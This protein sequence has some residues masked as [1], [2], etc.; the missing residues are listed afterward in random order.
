MSNLRILGDS[1]ADNS[2][3]T[4]TATS[5]ALSIGNVL[6]TQPSQVWRSTTTAA[7]NIDITLSGEKTISGFCLYN[8]NLSDGATIQLI[9]SNSADFSSPVSDTT[10]NYLDPQYGFGEGEYGGETGFGGFSEDVWRY[11]FFVRWLTTTAYAT[12]W[13]ITITDATNSDGYIQFGR[14]KLGSYWTP[15]INMEFGYGVK[16]VDPSE[17]TRTR[18]GAL[19][20]EN[21][22]KYRKINVKFNYLDASEAVSL[23]DIMR[24]IGY[25]SDILFDA[26]P[27]EGSTE[28]AVS[29]VL[30]RLT[31]WSPITTGIYGRQISITIQE[32]I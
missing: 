14:L 28:S 5:E 3:A 17:Q 22:E 9:G 26:L 7:Q 11:R 1:V 20:S 24:T 30:G 23:H 10:W 12:Y 19:R 6:N 21:K 15:A 2:T 4:V 13:R 31:D 27:E 29:T 32:S 18:G 8:H 25:Q 16:W